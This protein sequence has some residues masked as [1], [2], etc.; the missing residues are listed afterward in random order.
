PGA[1]NSFV[2]HRELVINEIM[3]HHHNMLPIATNMKP[4][5]SSEQWIE[6]YNRGS[7]TVTLTGWSLSGGIRYKFPNGRTLTAGAYLVVAN[8][9]A[10]LRSNYPSADIIGDFQGK[11]SHNGDTIELDDAAGNPVSTVTYS[12]GGRWPDAASG[13]GSSLELRDP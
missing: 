7:N 9:S 6:L 4:Q 12:T 11:L 1:S 3:Y 2:F 10:M 5:S 13:G 8:N